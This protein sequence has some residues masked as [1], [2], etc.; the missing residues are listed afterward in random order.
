MG[1]KLLFE[2]RRCVYMADDGEGGQ[3]ELVYENTYLTSPDAYGV[4]TKFDRAKVQTVATETIKSKMEGAAY[5]PVRSAQTAKEL[6]DMIKEKVKK[7]GYDR[8][9][10]MVQVTVGQKRGQGIRLATRCLWDTSSDN[11]A[12]E[13]YENESLFCVAQV[14]GLYYE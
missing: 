3:K 4:G 9:K 1:K 5:D 7:L 10:L 14:Y 12:S 2:E 8:Y 13:Y 11:F 6:S